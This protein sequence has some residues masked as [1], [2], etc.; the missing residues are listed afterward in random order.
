MH[1]SGQ[2][3]RGSHGTGTLSTKHILSADVFNPHS[4][5]SAYVILPLT[6][7]RH[8]NGGTEGL[9]ISLKVTRLGSVTAGLP[10]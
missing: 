9:D 3:S 2:H 6:L 5:P 7:C 10:V 8:G 1:I 4:K